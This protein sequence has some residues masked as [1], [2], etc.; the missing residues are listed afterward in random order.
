MHYKLTYMFH[1]LSYI[2][3]RKKEKKKIYNIYV[4]TYV[5]Y[6]YNISWRIFSYWTFDTKNKYNV[7]KLSCSSKNLFLSSVII[8]FYIQ[9]FGLII[10]LNVKRYLNREPG[11]QHLTVQLWAC[12]CDIWKWSSIFQESLNINKSRSPRIHTSAHIQAFCG[13]VPR[14]F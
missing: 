9:E 5:T 4:H 11:Y 6:L 3:K 2:K 12:L 13:T 8:T 1:K 10:I 7:K 14:S